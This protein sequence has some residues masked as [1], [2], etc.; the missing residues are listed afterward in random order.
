LRE[1]HD[2]YLQVG[3]DR[4]VATARRAAEATYTN[5]EAALLSRTIDGDAAAVLVSEQTW[6]GRL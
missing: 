2:I 6:G 5:V 1:D 3:G 4:R